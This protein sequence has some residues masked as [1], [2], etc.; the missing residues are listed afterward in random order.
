M[1]PIREDGWL[2]QC[3]LSHLEA[4]IILELWIRRTRTPNPTP[5]DVIQRTQIYTKKWHR[6]KNNYKNTEIEFRR[7]TSKLTGF[8]V[9]FI[10][11]PKC[12]Y[13]STPVHSHP[14]AERK[15]L[16][17]Y[18]LLFSSLCI[19]SII[20]S[21]LIARSDKLVHYRINWLLVIS[22]VWGV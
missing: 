5:E 18:L 21:N 4:Q 7:E 3:T 1:Q 11:T 14:R 15:L 2:N 22:L 16:S 6:G 17:H 9:F 20:F 10:T 13:T 8:C 12:T 19:K